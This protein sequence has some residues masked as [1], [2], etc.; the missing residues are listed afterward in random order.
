MMVF[1][2]AVSDAG[3]FKI[4]YPFEKLW[5]IDINRVGFKFIFSKTA[6]GVDAEGIG[7]DGR[8]SKTVNF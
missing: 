6:K 5:A 7:L 4:H 3:I 8:W 2:P 1:D